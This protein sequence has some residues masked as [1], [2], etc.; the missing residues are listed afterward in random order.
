MIRKPSL[1]AAFILFFPLAARAQEDVSALL[2][3]QTQEMVDAIASGGAKVWDR[4]VD[5][6]AVY[7][8]ED[9]SVVTKAELV[10][11]IKPLPPGVSG[12]IKVTDFKVTLHG[13]VAV[14]SYLSDEH[15]TYHGHELHCQYR[16]TD[17]WLRTP[18]GWRLI[19]GQV[20][21]VRTDPPA[22]ALTPAQ[23]DEYVGRYQLSPDVSYEIRRTADGLEGQQTGRKWEP[24]KAE[25][26]DVLFIPGKPR[27]RWLFQRGADGRIKS[28]VERR[29]AWDLDWTRLRGAGGPK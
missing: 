4:Y 15:E 20:L 10:D 2:Q 9:G 19:A 14:A 26:P 29:E 18:A 11:G 21:A 5:E 28:L 7:T 8:A 16:T 12:N 6:K 17:T 3:R 23:M 25:A 27:Y 13:D 22:V 1:L 24:I